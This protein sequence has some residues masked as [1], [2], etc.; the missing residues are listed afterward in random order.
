MRFFIPKAELHIAF[1]R[2]VHKQAN[3]CFTVQFR[4]LCNT[5]LFYEISA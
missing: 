2:C 4:L 1:R 5:Y 3:L